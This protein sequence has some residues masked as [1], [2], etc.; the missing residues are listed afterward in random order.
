MKEYTLAQQYTLTAIDGQEA[1]H[2]SQAKLAVCRGI[3]AA[4]MLEH[5]FLSGESAEK[6][7]LE[8]KLDEELKKIQGMGKR[9]AR[10]LEQEM[11]SLLKADGTLEEI[12]DLMACDINYSTMNME[13]RAYRCQE[14]IYRKI[15]EGMR[16]ELLDGGE[17]SLESLCLIWLFRESG[18]IPE[19]FS[20][21]EQNQLLS[22]MT[23]LT[24]CNP[25]A[26]ILWNTGF[27]RW[28]ERLS[29]NF[30][31]FKRE[32][33][34]NPYLEGVNL[35]FPFLERRQAVFIDFVVLGTSVADRRLAVLAFL[36]EKGHYVQEVPR[37][38][39]TL[40]KIDNYY[41]RIFPMTRTYNRIPVQGANL[42]PVYN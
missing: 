22:R 5:L 35:L 42:V 1:V 14:D 36:S 27:S 41:Y 29:Q 24:A 10:D 28:T 25:V 40:L 4:K 11:V 16:A 2:M 9:A 3:A 13:L 26:R 17:V 6:D 19:L 7:V 21:S 32:I 8:K 31:N 34:K 23:E 37:G 20:S 12:P 33:F 39:E 38:S 18:C 30:L 15:T